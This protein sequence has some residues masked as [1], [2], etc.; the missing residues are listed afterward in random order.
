MFRLDNRVAV[1]TGA[2]SGIGAAT[3]QLFA[4]MGA[5]L[6]LGTHSADDHDIES[7]RAS[8]VRL[9]RRVTVVDV[10]VRKEE[11]VN[12]LVDAAADE[13]GRIDVVIAN[14]AIARRKESS[15]LSD[16]EWND[17]LDVNLAG[18]WRTFR[19]AIPL[20]RE[21][22]YGRLLATAS[23]AGAFEAWQEH[24]HYSAAKA[25]ITGLVRSLAAELGPDG[26]T[27]NAIAPGIIETPQTLDAVNSL[28]AEGVGETGRT[29]P[30]RRVGV[31]LDIAKGFLFLGSEDT[32]FITGQT[33]II[34]GGRMLVRG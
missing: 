20:M 8:I 29:Q 5:D 6:V 1:I 27:V 18:V 19:A 34:D 15:I 22:G 13:Y 16:I 2:A 21:A 17:T 11:D 23:T 25:G 3:A 9:G 10:D 24:A 26:I 32:S 12:R 33:M 28:G 14:A 31:P 30:I 4:E 7:V